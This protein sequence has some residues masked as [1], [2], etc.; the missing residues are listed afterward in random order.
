M[1][2]LVQECVVPLHQPAQASR[3]TLL[4]E[5]QRIERP[6]ENIAGLGEHTL[7]QFLLGRE[8][9]KHIGLANSGG[10]RDLVDRHPIETAFR[11]QDF[12]FDQ[13]PRQCRF[14]GC[15]VRGCQKGWDHRR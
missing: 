13:D 7:I 8:M 5:F 6:A 12:G 2:T 1:R 4:L 9:M 14:L 10:Q 11:E 3:Q 15:F